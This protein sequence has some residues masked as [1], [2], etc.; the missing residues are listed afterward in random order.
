LELLS[1]DPELEG[2]RNEDFSS[3]EIIFSG[4]LEGAK[5]RA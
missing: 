4:G 2:G 5:E 3:R 1:F